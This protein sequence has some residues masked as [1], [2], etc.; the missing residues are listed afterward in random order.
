MGTEIPSAPAWK[1]PFPT[2]G[3][4]N[5]MESISRKY[6]IVLQTGRKKFKR[7]RAV[8]FWRSV[9]AMVITIAH[10]NSNW[11]VDT[12][13]CHVTTKTNFLLFTSQGQD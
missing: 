12:F 3:H 10:G 11:Y 7:R 9:P 1:Q 6:T 2:G 13:H 8:N 4:G 5:G